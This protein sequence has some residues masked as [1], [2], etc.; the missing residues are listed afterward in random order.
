MSINRKQK[1]DLF[2]LLITIIWSGTFI[3]IKNALFDVPPF[4]YTSLRFFAATF[5]GLVLWHKQCR[6][7]TLQQWKQ[8]SI[9]AIFFAL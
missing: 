4:L 9:L 5:I 7:I 8:G 1:A 6:N 2:M 3:I